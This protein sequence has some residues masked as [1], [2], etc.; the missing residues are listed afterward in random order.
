MLKR[1]LAF[2][3]L[4]LT[5]AGSAF[6]ETRNYEFN[7][8]DWQVGQLKEDAFVVD[9]KFTV[10]EKDGNKSLAVE[11]GELVEASVLLGD[12][13]KGSA[14]VQTKVLATRQG[15]LQPR[16]GIGV[17]GVSGY[18]L[19]VSPAKKQLELV[20]SEETIKSIPLDWTSGSWINIKLQVT[21]IGE[22]Q[23]KVECKSWA[24]GAEEPKEAQISHEDNTLRGQGKCSLLA[25]PYSGTPIYFDEVK[26]QIEQ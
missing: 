21:R 16:F 25:T 18:R 12:S 4:L 19:M 8:E 11:V 1:N 24:D 9:G 10:A 26:I 17:H 14:T 7:F 13:A 3:F 6:A 5:G 23:W 2:L 22:K 20:K 15:R